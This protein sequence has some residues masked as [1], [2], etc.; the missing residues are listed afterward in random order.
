MIPSKSRYMFRKES[1][2]DALTSEEA[3]YVGRD[4]HSNSLDATSL[5]RVRWQGNSY[6]R[7]TRHWS[8]QN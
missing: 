3:F 8:R 1:F 7:D 5:H 2:E 4:R 6:E